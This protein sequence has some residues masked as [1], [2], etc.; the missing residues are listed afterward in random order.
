MVCT[1]EPICLS[2]AVMLL[3]VGGKSNKNRRKD[4]CLPIIPGPAIP[5]MSHLIVATETMSPFGYQRAFHIQPSIGGGRCAKQA[6]VQLFCV[7]TPFFWY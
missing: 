7:A 2:L 5:R 4:S 1:S 3:S 6:L